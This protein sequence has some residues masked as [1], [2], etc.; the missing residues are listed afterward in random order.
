MAGTLLSAPTLGA[1]DWSTWI[2]LVDACRRG[3][4]AASYTN[5]SGSAE[6]ALAAGSLVEVAGAVYSFTATAI[7]YTGA[8]SAN[9]DLY[10]YVKPDAVVSTCSVVAWGSAP[11]WVDAKQG[12]YASAASTTRAVGGMY[13]SLTA[14]TYVRK[15]LYTP[16]NVFD[17]LAK[18]TT[19]PILRERFPIGEWDMD[20][21]E[22]L[23]VTL[24]AHRPDIYTIDA[25]V[26]DD[27]ATIYPLRLA[28]STGTITGGLMQG[29]IGQVAGADVSRVIVVLA[30]LTAGIF[31]STSF[32]ATAGTLANRGYIYIEY[33]A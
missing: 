14:G 16:E 27:T 32:N 21:S 28:A 4:L 20:T 15:Y 24:V 10:I 23:N 31:D 3:Y 1:S 6:S 8:G 30:R 13:V 26:F 5:F 17:C 25:F 11:V 2:T 33:E 12:F 9:S 18:N 29:W 19:R 22:T 7:D